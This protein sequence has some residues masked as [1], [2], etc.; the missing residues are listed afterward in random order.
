MR[1]QSSET[2][3]WFRSRSGLVLLAFLAVAAFFV[4]TEH[5]AHVLGHPPLPA[6]PRVSALALVPRRA[7]ARTPRSRQAWLGWQWAW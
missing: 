2:R 6:S 7:W 4:I 3:S 1:E 5:T